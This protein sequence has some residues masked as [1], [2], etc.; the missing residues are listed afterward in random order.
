MATA[1]IM[2]TIPSSSTFLSPCSTSRTHS[3]Q[4]CGGEGGERQGR[5]GEVGQDARAHTQG[6]E[7]T[8]TDMA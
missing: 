4:G 2:L 1:S 5:G 7:D 6:G 8:K 3:F